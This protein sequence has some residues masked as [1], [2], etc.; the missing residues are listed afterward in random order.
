MGTEENIQKTRSM[1]KDI[2]RNV[3]DT[4]KKG[5]TIMVIVLLVVAFLLLIYIIITAL[6]S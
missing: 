4:E 2:F 1:K 3:R 6:L 5:P